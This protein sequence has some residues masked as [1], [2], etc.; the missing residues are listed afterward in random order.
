MGKLRCANAVRRRNERGDFPQ[1][2]Q[3]ICSA[4]KLVSNDERAM[5]DR[6]GIERMGYGFGGAMFSVIDTIVIIGFVVI[7]GMIVIQAVN[8]TI[9]WNRN[10]QSPVLTVDAAVVTKRSQVS[11]HGQAGNQTAAASSTEYFVTFEVE[12]GDRME[13]YV[14]AQEYGMLA[15]G[16]VGKLTFQGSRYKEFIRDSAQSQKKGGLL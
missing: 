3:I 14:P 1:Q 7:L 11:V 5:K 13:F 4:F 15:E 8:G 10:N 2:S 6:G 16:D 12:S 9:Q